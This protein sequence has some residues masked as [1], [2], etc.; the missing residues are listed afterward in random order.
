MATPLSAA[1]LDRLRRYDTPTIAN[2]IETF[3]IRPRTAGF[4]SPSVRC[5]FPQ[6]GTM[7][8]YAVTARCRAALPASQSYSRHGWWDA[9]AAAPAPR[10][11]VI[12]DLD[13][14]PVGAFWGEVQSNIHRALGCVGAVTNGGV[15]DLREVEALGFQYYAGSVMVSHA[16]VTMVDYGT[17][18]TI[19]GLEIRPGDLVHADMHGVQVIPPEIARQIPDACEAIIAKERTIIDLCGSPQFSVDAL[20]RLQP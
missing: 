11:A 7:I 12:Q 17:P 8:G 4:A 3:D 13:E 16:Y 14:P 19:G 18:V 5:I 15:R 6:F 2:A 9:V 10:V 20:K 1:E